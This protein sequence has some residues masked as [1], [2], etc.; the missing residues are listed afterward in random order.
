MTRMRRETIAYLSIVGFCI[1]L[2]AWAIPVY[3]P[4]YPGYG[5]SPAL[6]P[7]VSVCIMLAMAILALVRNALAKYGGQPLPVEESQFPDEADA[8]GFT[9]VGRIKLGHLAMFMVPSALFV[10]AIEYIGYLPAA[11]IFMLIIQFVMRIQQFAVGNRSLVQPIVISVAAVGL[12]Y[13]VMRYGFGIP[14]PGPQL[15]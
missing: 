11:F 6:V 13:V 14:I 3:T 10:F 15:F 4:P 9:Q 12:M 5:A 2:L 7:V 1:L 8:G